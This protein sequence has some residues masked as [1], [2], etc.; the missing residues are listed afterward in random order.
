MNSF[1]SIFQGFC[2]NYDLSIF[3]SPLF[4]NTYFKEHLLL[5]GY[6]CNIVSNI[7]IIKKSKEIFSFSQKHLAKNRTFLSENF[8]GKVSYKIWKAKSAMKNFQKK[9]VQPS[10]RNS[11]TPSHFRFIPSNFLKS[12][13][14]HFFQNFQ[15][16]L[17]SPQKIEGCLVNAGAFINSCHEKFGQIPKKVFAMKS[18]FSNVTGCGTSQEFS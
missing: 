3:F 6:C 13:T 9:K 17:I 18:F 15:N 11:P 12:P 8:K 16:L 2:W 1:T 14:S 5:S 10:L 4:R 7:L